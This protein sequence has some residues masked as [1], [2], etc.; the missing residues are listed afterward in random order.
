MIDATE[1]EYRP[2]LRDCMTWIR[3]IY[4]RGY[5]M[6]H[7]SSEFRAVKTLYSAAFYIG[8]NYIRYM[9]RATDEELTAAILVYLN[10]R[11]GML[12][13]APQAK[14]GASNVD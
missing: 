7:H 9:R 6:G 5:L 8:G 3:Y 1:I 11:D 14:D 4:V 10:E 2:M 12:P 13:A